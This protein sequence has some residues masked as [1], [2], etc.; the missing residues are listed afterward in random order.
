MAGQLLRCPTCRA[1]VRLP[2]L[3]KGAASSPTA[4]KPDTPP[5]G[6]SETPPEDDPVRAAKRRRWERAGEAESLP[7]FDFEIPEEPEGNRA[8]GEIQIQAPS[9][10]P[11]PWQGEGVDAPYRVEPKWRQA[12]YLLA[13]V[14]ALLAVATS[15]PAL[16]RVVTGAA[17]AWAQLVIG[18]ALLQLAYGLW[19]ALLPHWASVRVLVWVSGAIASLYAA[20]MAVALWAPPGAALPLDLT[21]LRQTAGGRIAMWCGVVILTTASFAY[22]CG[23]TGANWRRA[24]LREAGLRSK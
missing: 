6:A 15:A 24:C 2:S 1:L 23:I 12:A 22:A 18:V 11:S 13:G 14:A 19:L 5:Q 3:D 20:G 7:D 17:P 10:R 21:D 9:P 8:A 4:A 16:P